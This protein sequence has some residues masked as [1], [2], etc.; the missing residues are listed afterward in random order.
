MKCRVLFDKYV[1]KR[2]FAR[3]Y[4]ETGKW[5]LQRLEKYRDNK[6][7]SDKPKYVGTL[8]DEGNDNKKLRTL[9]SCLRITYTSPKT[10]HWIT[11]ILSSLLANE[12]T[13]IIS[14]LE[15]YCKKKGC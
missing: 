13:D 15:N 3:D 7:N 12:A 1:L 4:K 6:K 11:V 2:E 9:Q 5:S 10:M 14:V 8:G